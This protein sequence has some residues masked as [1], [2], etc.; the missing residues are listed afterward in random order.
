MK[1]AQIGRTMSTVLKLK[2]KDKRKVGHRGVYRKKAARRASL[3]MP[4]AW[5]IGDKR[6]FNAVRARAV[7][8]IG[9]DPGLGSKEKAILIAAIDHMN[10]DERWS[11]WTSPKRLAREVGCH[12]ATAWR[13]I[14]KADGIHILTQRGAAGKSTDSTL[15][16]VH[17]NY[18]LKAK[19]HT[20]NTPTVCKDATLKVAPMRTEPT[21]HEPTFLPG[22][23]GTTPMKKDEVKRDFRDSNDGIGQPSTESPNLAESPR[24]KAYRLAAMLEGNVGRSLVAKAE[25]FGG[26]IVDILAEVEACVEAHGGLGLALSRFWKEEW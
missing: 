7:R 4:C 10:A 23:V 17:P 5:P 21:T 8:G 14:E 15:I 11:C 19:E 3:D 22:V 6:M 26:D 25:R 16:T 2:I 20:S 12:P 24:S 9:K 18:K 13:A 1:A